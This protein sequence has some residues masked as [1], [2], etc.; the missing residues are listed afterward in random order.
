MTNDSLPIGL[1]RRPL[2]RRRHRIAL[3]HPFAAM[4][5]LLRLWRRR[6]AESDELLA[7]SERELRDLGISRY[8]AEHA[9]KRAFWQS[10]RGGL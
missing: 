10:Y 7:M 5:R 8:D 9:A 6:L 1:A 4:A 3:P 2:P